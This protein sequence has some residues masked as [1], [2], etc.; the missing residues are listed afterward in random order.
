MGLRLGNPFRGMLVILVIQFGLQSCTQFKSQN[1]AIQNANSSVG[2]GGQQGPQGPLPNVALDQPVAPQP[3]NL[4]TQ[5][6]IP[7]SV[8]TDLSYSGTLN[9]TVSTQELH[10]LDTGNAIEF[11]FQPASVTV[12]NGQAS[13]Q[14]TINVTTMAPS[15]GSSLFHVVARDSS[16]PDISTTVQVPLQV[17]AIFN[18]LLNQSTAAT[19]P[20]NWTIAP[21]TVNFISHSEGLVFSFIN[22]DS[23]VHLIHSDGGPI[24]H[25]DDVNPYPG[26]NIIG[27]PSSPDGGI[28]AGGHYTNTV[29]AGTATVSPVHCHYHGGGPWTLQFNQDQPVAKRPINNP[30][31][32]FSY[33]NANI[34]QKTC[35]ACHAGATSQNGMVDLS[36]YQGVLARV[37][38][39]NSLVSSLY[40]AVSGST[41]AMPKTGTPLSPTLTQAIADW[42][43][44]G[45]SNN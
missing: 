3:M 6:T 22:M 1:A 34:F 37:T 9:F 33:L 45:A 20:E 21:G 35:I 23:E 38:P 7:I 11:S 19:G 4:G 32:T 5:I 29:S 13:T 39:N 41:P 36:S 10:Q 18:V 40:I 15:F 26:T 42:I 27:M 24:P 44:L 2:G 14:L 43:D 31:A 12:Q 17:Q 28:T 8:T 30:N 25:E 16:N